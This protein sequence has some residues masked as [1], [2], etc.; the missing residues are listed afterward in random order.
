MRKLIETI[1][2]NKREEIRVA[3]TKYEGHDLCDIR[4]FSETYTSDERVATKKGVCV[5]VAKLPDLI[6][7]L[8]KAEAEAR[9]AGLLKR[10]EADSV[11]PEA[12]PEATRG[13]AGAGD[14]TPLGAG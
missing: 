12:A 9:A 4:V 14:L 11:A 7:A 2:K 1:T 13:D 8:Q 6:E 5:S 10:S 3:L